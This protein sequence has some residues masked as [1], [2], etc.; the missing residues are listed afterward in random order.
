MLEQ[1]PDLPIS[2][3]WLRNNPKGK[4]NEELVK[5]QATQ[6]TEQQY[7]PA[8]LDEDFME[9]ISYGSG[10]PLGH[11]PHVIVVMDDS[12]KELNSILSA[13]DYLKEHTAASFVT[14]RSRRANTREGE[15]EWEVKTPYGEADFRS[16]QLTATEVSGI[17]QI[18][19]YLSYRN[20]YGAENSR[21]LAVIPDLHKLGI[22]ESELIPAA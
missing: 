8:V 16:K 22:N 18:N 19:R 11:T 17:L 2:Q 4:F 20:R 7:V 21:T 15:K 9:S 5:T 12:P 14:V 3:I 1:N 10:Y 6:K 13:N